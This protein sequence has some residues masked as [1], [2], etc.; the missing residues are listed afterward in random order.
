M[1]FS[2]TGTPGDSAM[3]DLH[4]YCPGFC[5]D[6]PLLVVCVRSQTLVG[7]WTHDE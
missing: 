5:A 4:F 3:L 7:V 1:C 2:A 6:K